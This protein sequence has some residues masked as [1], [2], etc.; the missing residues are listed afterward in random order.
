MSTYTEFTGIR[1]IGNNYFESDKTV[2]E[3]INVLKDIV[4]IALMSGFSK[5]SY[6]VQDHVRYINRIKTAKSPISYVKFVARK[7]FL[8]DK[9]ARDQAYA[10]KIAKV[11]ESYKNKQA[12]LPKFEALFVLYYD[13]IKEYASEDIPK[14]AVTWNDAEKTLAELL[15]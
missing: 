3:I 5:T 12:L 7:L 15:A 8:E 13:L 9:D 6:L 2:L 14:N 11:H 4:I 10:A 1:S